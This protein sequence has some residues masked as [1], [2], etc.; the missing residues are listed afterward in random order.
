MFQ[1]P[2]KRLTLGEFLELPET[3]PVSEYINGQIIQKPLPQGKHSAIQ[4][5]LATTINTQLKPLRIA[6][7]F[8]EL[9][10]TFAGRSIVPDVSI[11]RWTRISREQNGEIAHRA[12]LAPDWIMKILSPDQSQTQVIKNILH[13]LDYGTQIAWLIDPEERTIFV[14]QPQQQVLVF[15][16]PEQ[17][18]PIPL[19]ATDLR[20]TVE[21]VFA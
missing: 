10:C 19:F 18:L 4:T 17:R 14:Y 15:D 5:E 13:C 7:A 9:R 21:N 6:Q 3:E 8:A 11:F 12:E 1:A 20:L 16:S 2:L